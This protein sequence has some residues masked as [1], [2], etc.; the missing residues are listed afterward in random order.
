MEAF[1]T[2]SPRCILCVGTVEEG[3]EKTLGFHTAGAK[4]AGV[5]AFRNW[6]KGRQVL[7]AHDAAGLAVPW[8]AV[9]AFVR[10]GVEISRC[11][12]AC[13]TTSSGSVALAT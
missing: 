4:A 11:L 3:G 1:G 5:T 9:F 7:A 6:R 8:K 10:H 13:P 12:T 2:R